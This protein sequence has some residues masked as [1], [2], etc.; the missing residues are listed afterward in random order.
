M[1]TVARLAGEQDAEFWLK[2][3]FFVLSTDFSL[4][5]LSRRMKDDLI[6]VLLS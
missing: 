5:I 4:L 1:L 3:D 6:L 2:L